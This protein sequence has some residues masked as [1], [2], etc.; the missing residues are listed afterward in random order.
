MN[1]LNL[2]ERV[3]E[4]RNKKGI[5]QEILARESGLSIRTIQRIEKNES[6]P[7]GDTLNRLA[8]ALDTSS[9]K[10]IDNVIFEDKKYLIIMNLSTL[11]I[12]FFPF[13]G[14][15]FPL[16][17]WNYKKSKIKGVNQLGKSII[18]FEIIWLIL[19]FSYYGLLFSGLYIKYADFSSAHNLTIYNL[20][21]I[22][23][24]LILYLFTVIIIIINTLRI[25]KGQSTNYILS[26]PFLK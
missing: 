1:H 26:Y 22:T 9:D 5:S 20:K 15:L 2:S 17:L 14:I 24:V 4:L 18:N 3:K 23:P 25:S 19:L 12:L 7:R 21:V 11:G 10:I 8:M 16:F 6:V 13:F